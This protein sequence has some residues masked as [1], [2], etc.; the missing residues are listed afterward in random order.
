MLECQLKE[1]LFPIISADAPPA[2]RQQSKSAQRHSRYS[3]SIPPPAFLPRLS[4][5]PTLRTLR[6]PLCVLCIFPLRFHC[7]PLAPKI[8]SNRWKTREKFFQSLEKPARIFQPLEKYFPIIG[9]PAFPRRATRLCQTQARLPHVP[10]HS[11]LSIVHCALCIVHGLPSRVPGRLRARNR[12]RARR[13]PFPR[14]LRRRRSGRGSRSSL[15]SGRTE[16][17]RRGRPPARA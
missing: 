2:S 3:C 12:G 13:G 7:A 14:G 5:P 4:R 6:Q 9:K 17:S 1:H 11:P 8:F 10:I 16:P 15:P